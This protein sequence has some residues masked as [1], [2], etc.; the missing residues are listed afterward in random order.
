MD[1]S[2]NSQRNDPLDQVSDSQVMFPQKALQD[3][4]SSLERA[5]SGN[6]NYININ[7]DALKYTHN[8]DS[9]FFNSK[10]FYYLLGTLPTLYHIITIWMI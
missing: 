6:L 8:I 9:G 4:L 1:T 3:M 10:N 7:E 2:L 5:K